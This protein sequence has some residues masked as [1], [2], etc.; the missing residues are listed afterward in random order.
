MAQ[1]LCSAIDWWSKSTP[2]TRALSLAGD[3]VTYRELQAWCVRIGERLA[4]LGIEPGARVGICAANSLE[5]CA[6]L[7]GNMRAG[8]INVPLNMRYTPH[9]IAEVVADTEPA[10][11]FCDPERMEKFDRLPVRTLPIA[12]IAALRHGP[13]S[14]FYR[15]LDTDAPVVIIATSGSTA[16]PKG[17]VYS[18]RSMI[19]YAMGFA[20][21]ETLCAAGA[22]VISA[23]PLSTSAGFVQLMH[24][25]TNGCSL[26][27]EPVFDPARFLRIL[28]DEK[29]NCF[30][31]VPTFFER[32]A[33]CPGFA[34]ADLSELRMTTVGGARVSRALQ[35]AWMT[36]GIVLRQIYGQTE[37]GGNSTIMPA[38]LALKHPEK[39]GRGGIFSDIAIVD[40]QGNRCPPN[41]QGQIIVRGP[42]MMVGYWRNPEATASTIRDGWLYTGDIGVLD[43]DGLLTFIDRMKDLIIS[44]GL[45]ISAA[46]VERAVSEFGGIEEVAVIAA[47]DPRFGETPMAIVY[48]SGTVE[49]EALICHCNER[50][51]DYKVPRYVVVE[52]EPLPRLATGK[53]SKPA[54]RQ[55]YKDQVASLARVR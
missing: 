24:Y 30:G 28:V 18:H 47:P 9:E 40:E 53:L 11:V 42:G 33:A 55:K 10:I 34:A 49:V 48:S 8:A 51:A 12:E 26:Y 6:L 31:A 54:L 7:M 16:K 25:T 44:G 13:K 3:T 17:V 22:R 5:Y 39:C 43:E 46:E 27:L 2:D 14:D 37:A 21:E 52:S 50:L 45:N 29:I 32:I 15:E 4:A 35:D 20:L 38:D 36:K 1:T 23:A 19:G 41:V